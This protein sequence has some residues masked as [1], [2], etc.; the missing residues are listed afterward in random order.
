LLGL[1][2]GWHQPRQ[3]PNPQNAARSLASARPVNVRVEGQLI[4]NNIAL[5]RQG[6][7]GG[8]GLAYLP[9]DYVQPLIASGELVRVLSNWCEPFPGYH[10]YYPSQ[11]RP[12]PAFTLLVETLR[13]CG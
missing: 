13:Y 8:S 3:R 10:L 12:T 7:L 1:D 2:V 11:R 4:V 6:A 5:A 9:L